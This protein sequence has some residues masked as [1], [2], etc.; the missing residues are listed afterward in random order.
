MLKLLLPRQ[1]KSHIKRPRTCSKVWLCVLTTDKTSWYKVAFFCLRRT[2]TASLHKWVETE[3]YKDEIMY[4][5]VDFNNPTSFRA[6]QVF[7][8]WE[9]LKHG[10]RAGVTCG[11][12]VDQRISFG[13]AFEQAKKHLSKLKLFHEHIGAAK[14]P[15]IKVMYDIRF[16]KSV[17]KTKHYLIHEMRV[18]F[19]RKKVEG[20]D[21]GAPRA[22]YQVVPILRGKCR[23]DSLSHT[24]TKSSNIIS[25]IY[26][27]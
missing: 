3:R 14:H 11:V 8:F 26:Y 2:K 16:S 19:S 9:W 6:A 1:A 12:L 18:N 17:K 21:G 25:C 23:L 13:D 5:W 10:L 15:Q 20:V 22:K 4:Y 7:I 24:L 27:G